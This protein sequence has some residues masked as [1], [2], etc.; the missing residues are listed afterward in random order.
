M[1]SDSCKDSASKSNE[2]VC[3]VKDMLH[4][5]S[6][7]DDKEEV[8]VSVCANCGK[9]GSDV[10]TN[11]CNKCNEVMYCN[12]ACKKKHRHKHKKE[13]ERRVAELHD[14]ALFKQPPQL[15]DCPICYLRM[16]S[17]ISA[18]LYQV[19]CGKVICCGCMHAVALRDDDKLCPFCRTPGTTSDE[20]MLNRYKARMKVNDAAAI[21]NIGGF[22]SRGLVGCPQNYAKALKLYQRAA[23]LGRAE[24]FNN[25]GNT[26]AYGRGV[27]IDRKKAI[28]YWEL[29]AM[30]G[31]VEARNKLGFEEIVVGSIGG[32]MDRALKHLMIAVEG[33][34]KDSLENIKRLYMNGHATKDDYATALGKYQ[35]YVDEIKSVQR[36][37]AAAY[38][39]DWEYY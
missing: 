34:H 14:E 13:C 8:I 6:T 15:G 12:A 18:Q 33:G 2:T 17:V 39:A 10:V 25:I 35:A 31:V 36:D 22:H 32:N 24:S 11:T 26:Y 23:E 19:C 16:P 20:E 27:E 30:G 3:D 1:S 7:T 28:H 4:N 38:D 21:H 9:E 5:M 37:E 29:A